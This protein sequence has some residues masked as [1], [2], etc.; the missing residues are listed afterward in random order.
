VDVAGGGGG[1]DGVVVAAEGFE[2]SK[3]FRNAGTVEQVIQGVLYFLNL[4]GLGLDEVLRDGSQRRDS[5]PME[6]VQ[7]GC[8]GTDLCEV[9]GPQGRVQACGS[10]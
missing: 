2:E 4:P 9:G 7:P 10:P 8:E 5:L 3:A 1:V 6:I